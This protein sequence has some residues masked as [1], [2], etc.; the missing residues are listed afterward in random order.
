MYTV[1]GI[2]KVITDMEV[3]QSELV[4]WYSHN[5]TEIVAKQTMLA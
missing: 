3:K 1:Y 4:F 5:K 2:S